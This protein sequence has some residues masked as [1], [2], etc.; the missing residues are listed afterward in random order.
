MEST[1]VHSPPSYSRDPG[2]HA[3]HDCGFISFWKGLSIGISQSTFEV[4]IEM[5]SCMECVCVCLRSGGW[6]SED[7][8]EGEDV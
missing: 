4:V 6:F 2:T 3:H 1:Q 7:V 8:K 5:W